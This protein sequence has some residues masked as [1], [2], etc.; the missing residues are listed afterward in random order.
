MWGCF[1]YVIL[2]CSPHFFGIYFL[3]QGDKIFLKSR[4][5]QFLIIIVFI[6]YE[7]AQ[8]SELVNTKP[9][10]LEEIKGRVTVSLGHNIFVN[11][12]IHNFVL[13][14]FLFKDT[15]FNI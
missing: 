8:S 5:S 10:L 13:C 6:F 9:S 14:V 2:P 4:Y 7:I 12:A 1:S 3:L 15:L 11:Q